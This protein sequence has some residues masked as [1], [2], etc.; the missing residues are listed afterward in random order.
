MKIKQILKEFCDYFQRTRGVGHT[1][2]MLYGVK[3]TEKIIGVV[4]YNLAFA[5]MLCNGY[6][7][8]CPIS[9]Q[10]L[11]HLRGRKIP[12]AFDNITLDFLFMKAYD[13]IDN[14]EKEIKE[15][16]SKLSKIVK[17]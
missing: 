4:G 8:T 11:T 17:E 13:T 16:K 2:L 14:Q 7:N 10:T 1:H 15:L 9:I 3:N 12:L 5:K 6:K